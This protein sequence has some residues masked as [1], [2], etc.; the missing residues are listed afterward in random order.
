LSKKGSTA[1]TDFQD[2]GTS[3]PTT[4]L[5]ETAA[6]EEGG[7]KKKKREI[8]Y[9]FKATQAKVSATLG[10]LSKNYKKESMSERAVRW[11]K[12]ER[13]EVLHDRQKRSFLSNV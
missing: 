6:K 11:C 12:G 5:E 8:S 10:A 2:T 3:D 4:K 1:K 7:E 13:K 9:D